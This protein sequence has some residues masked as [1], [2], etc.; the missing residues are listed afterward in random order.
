MFK[1]IGEASGNFVK[2]TVIFKSRNFKMTREAS[3]I[4]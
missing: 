1:L 4:L 3:E 2:F